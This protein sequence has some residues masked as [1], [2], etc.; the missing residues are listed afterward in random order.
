MPKF[1]TDEEMVALESTE[2]T[3]P[4]FISDA[5]MEQLEASIAAQS[6]S[7]DPGFGP[8]ADG[9]MRNP[10]D[11]D[12]IG[13]I[14]H[15]FTKEP[16]PSAKAVLDN[17]LLS[18]VTPAGATGLG[19]TAASIGKRA[20]GAVESFA[21]SPIPEKIAAATDVVGKA[22]GFASKVIGGLS[23]HLSPA[24]QRT[25][26]VMTE[27]AGRKAAYSNPLTAIPQAVSDTARVAKGAQ[28]GVAWILDNAPQKLG[29]FAQP[30]RAAADRGGSALATTSFL[31][32]Q[33]DPEFQEAMKAIN[34]SDD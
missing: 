6:P 23:E 5:E 29:K 9:S 24:A 21:T 11:V 27:I 32:Q 22:K 3:K 10:L 16:D 14:K 30:L 12:W 17:T 25:A 8:T 4:G 33:S 2:P 34:E 28:K 26:N 1:I 13:A 19:A 7:S 15:E 20:L 31:L 18:S